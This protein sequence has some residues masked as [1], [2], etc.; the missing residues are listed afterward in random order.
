MKRAADVEAGYDALAD[1]YADAFWDELRHKPLDRAL[2]AVLAEH[3][4]AGLV[5]DVGCGPGHVARWL[6]DLGA[7]AA[8]LDLS[9]RSIAIARSRSPDVAFHV[10]SMTAMPFADGEVAAIAALYAIVHFDVEELAGVFREMGRVLA[11]DGRALV[12]FHVGAERVRPGEMLGRRTD[13]EFVFFDPD[14]V[15]AAMESAGL[16]IDARVVR[17]PYATEH[18]STRAYLFARKPRA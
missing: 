7:R 16:A 18:P 8:G 2:L 3:A 17:A 1:A 5:V 11:P 15:A 13:L 14:A 9:A 10:A 6:A 12:S 4:G